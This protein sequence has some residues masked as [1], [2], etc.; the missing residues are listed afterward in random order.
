MHQVIQ[1]KG[2]ASTQSDPPPSARLLAVPAVASQE[3]LPAIQNLLDALRQVIGNFP[4]EDGIAAL[5]LHRAVRAKEV[6][7]MTGDKRSHFYARLNST[8]PSYDPTFPRPFRLG[9]SVRAPT[10]WWAH[11]I[12]T[13]LQSR[14]ISSRK[15]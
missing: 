6:M 1:K 12:V 9:A 7:Q 4:L 2:W 3:A 13:W 14:A 11:E 10:V 5:N 15:N 8:S